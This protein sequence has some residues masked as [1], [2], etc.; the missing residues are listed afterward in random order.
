MSDCI[1]RGT[2]LFLAAALVIACAVPRVA[3]AAEAGTKS[4]PTPRASAKKHYTELVK[5]FRDENKTLRE[6]GKDELSVVFVGDSL[7]ERFDLKAHFPQRRV[8]NRGIGSDVI[9]NALAPDDNRGLLKRMD[10]SLFDFHASDAFLMIGVNDIGDGHTPAEMEEG[11]RQIIE[12]IKKR[13]PT[14]RVH[15]QSVLPM[16]GKYSKDNSVVIEFNELLR[17]LAKEFDYD[18]ID[19]HSR[20]TDEKGELKPE[21]TT[22]DV[23]LTP[24]G[25]KIWTAEINRAMSW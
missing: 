10:E 23:H 13:A 14:L 1:K 21:L 19:L 9:G 18:Y 17:R 12:R 2:T 15:I 25:Y 3:S 6:Q 20:M 5:K 22:D 4:P 7:T 11:Y 8:V 24:A 16:R